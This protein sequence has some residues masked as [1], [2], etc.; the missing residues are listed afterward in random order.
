MKEYTTD[1]AK[2]DG[3]ND[4]FFANYTRIRERARDLQNEIEGTHLSP[5]YALA[6][7]A[8][9]LEGVLDP[10]MIDQISEISAYLANNLVTQDQDEAWMKANGEAVSDKRASPIA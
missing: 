6:A 7:L 4:H 9:T 1:L 10:E 8:E 2:T 3:L 5:Y